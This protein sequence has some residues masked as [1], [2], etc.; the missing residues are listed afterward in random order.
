MPR[1]RLVLARRSLTV[2][3]TVTPPTDLIANPD[4][5]ALELQAASGAEAIRELHARLGAVGGGVT[6]APR[7]LADLMERAAIA[8]V[9]IAADVALPHA[10]TAGVGRMVLAVGRSTQDVAFDPEHP[11]VRLV[12][13]I[14]TPKAAVADYLKLVAGLSRLLKKPGV[15]AGLLAAKTEAEFLALLARG[16]ESKR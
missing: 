14:G 2:P 4:V 11:G 10:R 15:R 7:F 9:C 5:L 16:A 1:A 13:L 12:F 8:S 3:C 6:D